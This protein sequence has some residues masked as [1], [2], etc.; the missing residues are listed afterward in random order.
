MRGNLYFLLIPMTFKLLLSFL[1]PSHHGQGHIVLLGRLGDMAGKSY[2]LLEFL[3]E[4]AGLL[5]RTLCYK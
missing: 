2:F 1:S 3:V 4:F 5:Q